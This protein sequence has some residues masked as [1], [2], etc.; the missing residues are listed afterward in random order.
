MK[1]MFVYI[2]TNCNNTVIYVGVTNH[3]L[4]RVLEHKGGLKDGFT[5]R[6]NLT[7]LVYYEYGD[8]EEGAILREKYL[9]KCY[10]K[11]KEWLITRFN[12]NWEDLTDKIK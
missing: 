4:R 1:T 7:K 12:P 11:Y 8:G 5:K 2:M 9:K 6:Y 10:R 3:L